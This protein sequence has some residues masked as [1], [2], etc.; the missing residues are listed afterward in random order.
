MN[1]TEQLITPNETILYKHTG[2]VHIANRLS[3]VE[4]KITTSLWKERIRIF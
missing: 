4:R 2:T 3:F 1:S